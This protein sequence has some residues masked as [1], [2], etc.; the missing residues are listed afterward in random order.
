MP[1][2]IPTLLTNYQDARGTRLA[3][4]V[5]LIAALLLLTT[6]LV[7]L[8]GGTSQ[9]YLHFAYLPIIL[10]AFLFYRIGG[11][12]TGLAAGLLLGPL[13][14][15]EAS[16]GT[17]QE[18]LSWLFR[19]V[20]FVL[21]GVFTGQL[22][23]ALSR[24][25]ERLTETYAET[26]RSFAALVA[27]RDEQVSGH[28][29]RVARNARVVGAAFGLDEAQLDQIYW[30]GLLHD[31]GKV[32]IPD[33]I[34]LKTGPLSEEEFALVK[35]HCTVGAD[36]VARAGD[37]F[38][39]LAKGIRTHHER[40]DGTGYPAGL[41]GNQIPLDGRILGVVD[42]FEALTSERP[43][44]RSVGVAAACEL[45]RRESGG[46][47]DPIV[48]EKFLALHDEGRIEVA[49]SKAEAPLR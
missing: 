35:T 23:R 25:A 41:E 5:A 46:H 16:T 19:V 21:V 39:P 4:V 15:L 44:R 14:P 38:E 10:A 6:T 49:V 20:V 1:Q 34:L 8:S 33:R 11:L 31:L 9:A 28:C 29:E 32:A 22:A 2:S 42:V 27:T 17:V 37:E 45:L 30:A 36:L 12:L 3:V 7:Y 48:V 43:Y 18:P 40:W 26:L 47:F 13:M 24:R